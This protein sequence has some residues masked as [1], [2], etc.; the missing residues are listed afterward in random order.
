MAWQPSHSADAPMVAEYTSECHD[1]TCMARTL[2]RLLSRDNINNIARGLVDQIQA[3]RQERSPSATTVDGRRT[4]RS[5]S[6]KT[7]SA[8][9]EV[10]SLTEQAIK[11]MLLPYLLQLVEWNFRDVATT[12]ISVSGIGSTPANHSAE[13]SLL[14]LDKPDCSCQVAKHPGDTNDNGCLVTSLLLRLLTKMQDQQTGPENAKMKTQKLPEQLLRE[15][16]NASGTLDFKEYQNNIKLQTL[17]HTLNTLLLKNFG[18]KAI[19]QKPADAKDASFDDLLMSALTK[20]LLSQC[21][22]E[23]TA[24]PSEITPRRPGREIFLKLKSAHGNLQKSVAQQPSHY[25]DAPAQ[26]PMAAEYT[27]ESHDLTCMARTLERLLS[28]DNINNIAKGLVDQIQA[29]QQ[30]RSPIP[31]TSVD[32]RG[33]PGSESPKTAPQ[34]TQSATQEVCSFIEQAIKEMLLPYLLPLV[35]WNVRD[36]ATTGIFVSGIGSTPA[37]H[38]AEKSLLGLDKPDCSCQVAKHPGV[39]NDNGCLVTS[40]LLRLL[41]KMQ[42]QQTG[43]EN[44][45]TETRKLLEQLLREF[46]NASGNLDFKEYQNNI[47]LQTLYHTLNTLLLKNFGPKAILQ[48]PADA[49]DSSFDDL[50]MSALTKELLSQCDAEVTVIP[51]EITPRRPGREIFLK[52]KSALGNLKKSVAQQPSH[53]ADAPTQYPMA[54]E[55]TSESRDLTCMARTLERLLCRD[56]INNIAK[57]L[58]HQIQAVQEERSPTPTTVDGRGT[59]GSESPKAAP[60]K[61][62]SATQEVCSFTEQAIKGMLQPY[63]PSLVEWNANRDVATSRISVSEIKDS[64][65]DDLLMSALTKELL[66]QCDAEVTAIPSAPGAPSAPGVPPSPEPQAGSTGSKTRRRWFSFKILKRHS[67]NRVA[68]SAVIPPDTKKSNNADAAVLVQ[69][70]RQRSM[71]IGWFTSCFKCSEES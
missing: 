27:S 24:I 59:P 65:F 14:G 55:Y 45:K 2:E 22:A 68:P 3:V 12:G 15:F 37:N 40:L 69:K 10:C 42:D 8:T 19:L 7:L 39:T 9:Q 48:K 66:S 70:P 13:K 41:T 16:T 61:A 20:E 54:A 53:S 30:E 57:D 32:G 17:Y 5:D 58:V 49:K 1:L 6:S 44:A 34:K 71:F 33:T 47:K 62:S 60:Q 51:S 43:P 46:T 38:S 67:K 29:V 50:L 56:N 25:A 64:S 11:G 26:C 4:P 21:D 23:V 52:L 31:I 35:E 36:V 18:P 63:L 28:R